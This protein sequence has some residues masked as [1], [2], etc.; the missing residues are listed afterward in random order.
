VGADGEASDATGNDGKQDNNNAID[1]GAV[2]MTSDG[3]A[4][5]WVYVKDSSNAVYF[6]KSIALSEDRS[7]MT[8]GAGADGIGEVYIYS[9][10]TYFT[11]SFKRFDKNFIFF[12]KGRND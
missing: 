4:S 3:I 2:Y 10:L 12:T 1:Y 5:Q 11:Y 6:G 8:V 9:Q 7:T